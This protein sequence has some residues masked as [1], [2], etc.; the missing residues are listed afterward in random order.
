MDDGKSPSL[1]DKSA[2]GKGLASFRPRSLLLGHPGYRMPRLIRSTAAITV[3]KAVAD[4]YVRAQ[5]PDGRRY[6]LGIASKSSRSRSRC[7]R[8]DCS[9]LFDGLELAG[10]CSPSSR[11]RSV[12]AATADRRVRQVRILN[13]I[14][15]AVS[16]FDTLFRTKFQRSST[17]LSRVITYSSS[18][19][20]ST[21][22]FGSSFDNQP[23]SILSTPQ[24]DQ[25][26]RI[27]VPQFFVTVSSRFKIVLAT[28]VHA[29][30]SLASRLSSRADSPTWSSLSAACG[31]SR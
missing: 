16:Q 13:R 4:L 6:P 11:R 8:G 25:L 28:I 30:S 29:A 23:V 14:E 24:V 17:I 21:C 5:S 1:R 15:H 12:S 10:S 3:Q 20:L 18:R 19:L 2:K 9:D 7:L 26:A 27:P 31:S 22:Q